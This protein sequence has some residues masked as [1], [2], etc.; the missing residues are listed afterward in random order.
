MIRANHYNRPGSLKGAP[1]VKFM[2]PVKTAKLLGMHINSKSVVQPVQRFF[3]ALTLHKHGCTRQSLCV[4]GVFSIRFFFIELDCTEMHFST[5]LRIQLDFKWFEAMHLYPSRQERSM[6]S[7]PT[8]AVRK[9]WYLTFRLA[10][11]TKQT[12]QNSAGQLHF[13]HKWGSVKVSFYFLSHHRQLQGC[14][15][16]YPCVVLFSF[17]NQGER[18]FTTVNLVYSAVSWE[19]HP[20][21]GHR[22]GTNQFTAAPTIHQLQLRSSCG[23]K[24]YTWNRC[25]RI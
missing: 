5:S 12:K 21:C 10:A 17:H 11:L 2:G 23:V 15:T 18:K 1:R 22:F 25:G 7:T 6:Y 9:F 14:H 8:S 16:P 3:S 4:G 13:L 19:S 24:V 20:G